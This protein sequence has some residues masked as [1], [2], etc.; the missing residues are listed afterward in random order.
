[1]GIRFSKPLMFLATVVGIASASALDSVL[2]WVQLDNDSPMEYVSALE[3]S[4]HRLYAAASEGIF[5]LK[6][7][8]THG[9]YRLHSSMKRSLLPHLQPLKIPFMRERGVTAF[10]DPMM[11]E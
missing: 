11:L 6:T 9:G 2:E 1:M 7:V 8:G 4:E 3:G 5:S 10:S